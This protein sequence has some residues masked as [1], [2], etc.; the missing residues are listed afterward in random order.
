MRARP[1]SSSRGAR[2]RMIGSSSRT[3]TTASPPSAS[4]RTATRWRSSPSRAPSSARPSAPSR[5]AVARRH[6]RPVA[7]ARPGRHR[8]VD[9]D[10]PRL[11]VAIEEQRKAEGIEEAEVAGEGDAAAAEGEDAGGGGGRAGGVEARTQFFA[12]LCLSLTQIRCSPPALARSPFPPHSHAGLLLALSTLCLPGSA[13]PSSLQPADG[14]MPDTT[15]HYTKWGGV[16]ADNVLADGDWAARQDD[17]R[18][19]SA[20]SP[21]SA[22]RSRARRRRRSLAA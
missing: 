6:R 9:H 14:G 1:C 18:R 17:A 21:S 3:T 11:R 10:H 19:R 13:L 12:T 2:A 5:A 7:A 22:R 8:R 20:T 16:R 4:S 15:L